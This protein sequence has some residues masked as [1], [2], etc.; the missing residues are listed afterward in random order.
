MTFGGALIEDGAPVGSIAIVEMPD[1]AALDAWLAEH[2]YVVNQ[3]WY[4]IKVWSVQPAPIF[5]TP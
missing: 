1:R 2:P 3:I 5:A 4:D